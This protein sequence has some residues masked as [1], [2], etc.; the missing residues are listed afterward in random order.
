MTCLQM[1][2]QRNLYV[3]KDMLVINFEIMKEGIE[4]NE[5]KEAKEARERREWKNNKKKNKKN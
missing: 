1:G 5:A 3:I 2:I 4:G